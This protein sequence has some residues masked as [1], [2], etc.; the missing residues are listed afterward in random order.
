MSEKKL[1]LGIRRHENGSIYIF[2]T[3]ADG[4]GERRSLGKYVTVKMAETQRKLWM[5]EID[6]GRYIKK[7]KRTNQVLFADICDKAIEHYKAYTRGWDCVAG[8]ATRFKAWWAGR[9]A[10]S[11]T[12]AEINAQLLANTAPNGLKW[13]QCTANE[14]RVSLLRIFS[15]AIKRGELTSNPAMAAERFKL[16]NARTPELSYAEEDNLRS[17]ILRKYPHKLPE[18]DLALHLGCRRSNL[19]GQHNAKRAPMAPLQWKDVNLDFRTVTFR[20]SKSGKAYQIPLNRSAL[21]AFKELAKRSDGTGA[22]I[23][24]P[25]GIELQ[26]SRRWFE[27]CLKEAK[28]LDFHWHDFRHVFGSRLRAAGTQIEDIRY[29]LGHGA[30]SITERYAHPNMDVLRREVAKLD[31][32]PNAAQTDLKTDIVPVLEFPTAVGT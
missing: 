5:R 20:R 3:H 29:L 22:V 10:E 26:S 9:T 2:L 21:C 15:L 27:N 6:E 32:T 31:R 1:P 30:K 17:V 11:I 13:T 14:Y 4:T 7:V 8:R 18:F 24:K 23:R 25:S 19:Y 16:E 28:I 12:T